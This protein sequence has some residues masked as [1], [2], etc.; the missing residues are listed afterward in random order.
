MIL[1]GLLYFFVNP[2]YYVNV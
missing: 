1:A 2:F